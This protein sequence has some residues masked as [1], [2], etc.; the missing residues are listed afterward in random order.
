MSRKI[1]QEALEELNKEEPQDLLE[2]AREQVF[3]TADEAG[4]VDAVDNLINIAT[5]QGMT[6]T[7]EEISVYYPEQLFSPAPYNSFRCGNLWYKTVVMPGETKEEAYE[8]AWKFVEQMVREQ[9]VRT[10][11]EFWDRY[12]SMNI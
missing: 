5:Q 4:F 9:Y 8:R 6:F 11:K 10:K 2:L 3:L 1:D 12:N 7:G